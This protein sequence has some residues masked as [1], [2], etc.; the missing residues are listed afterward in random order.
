MERLDQRRNG[1]LSTR[2]LRLWG[3]FFLTAGVVGRGILQNRLLGVGTLTPMEL[4]AVMDSSQTMMIVATAA[5][6]LQV[7][8]TCAVPVFAF[9]LVEGF[10]R[11]KDVKS[12][13][14]RILAVALA[15]EIPYNL[16]MSGK[17][18]DMGSRNP[19][20]GLVLGMLVLFFYQH[21]SERSFKH[22]L[23]KIIVAVAAL[24]WGAMLQ[25]DPNGVCL[26]L[27]V[28]VLW[29]FRKS[30]LYRTFA[31]AIATVGCCLVSP[32]FIAAP[33]G[34]LLVHFYNGS[35]GGDGDTPRA[36]KYLAYPVLLLAV[37]A[38]GLVL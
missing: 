5:L 19:S 10:Q 25:L 7:L 21:Y 15:S 18:L 24:L 36:V 29:C 22:I 31:G 23:V 35:Q 26:T 32:L 9:L 8:E 38:V 34:F 17:V 30:T 12:Y 28:C 33:M 14:G 13:F 6:I 2:S 4:L 20:F 3:F 37:F 27:A 16:V 1:G 11:S